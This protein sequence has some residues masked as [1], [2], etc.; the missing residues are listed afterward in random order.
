MNVY[1]PSETPDIITGGF[2][3]WRVDLARLTHI[4]GKSNNG[5]VVRRA[6]MDIFA[7]TTEPGGERLVYNLLGQLDVNPDQAAIMGE[8]LLR[9]AY[10]SRDVTVELMQQMGARIAEVHRQLQAEFDALMD[11]ARKGDDEVV[12]TTEQQSEAPGPSA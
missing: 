11:A 7:V 9:Y 12:A 1:K 3:I 5:A 8:M 2:P 6:V 4:H 10:T